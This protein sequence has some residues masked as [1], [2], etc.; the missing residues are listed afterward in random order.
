M[1]ATHGWCT[2]LTHVVPTGRYMFSLRSFCVFVGT[3]VVALALVALFVPAVRHAIDS[4]VTYYKVRFYEAYLYDDSDLEDDTSLREV[5]GVASMRDGETLHILIMGQSNAANEVESRIEDLEHVFVEYYGNIYRASDPMLGGTGNRGSVWTRFAVKAL[6]TKRWQNVVLSII[7][8]GGSALAYWMP[9]G[10]IHSRL[11]ARLE[12][13]QSL[14]F[15]P[16][17]VFW[18]HGETDALNDIPKLMYKNDF[19]D[20]VG[21]LR[22]FGIDNQVLVSQTT[23][24]RRMGSV[25]VRDALAEAADVTPQVILGPDT[26]AVG[27]DYRRDGCHFTDDGGDVVAGLWMDAVMEQEQAKLQREAEIKAAMEED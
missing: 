19:I 13:M 17:Y 12:A 8:Q 26:D 9:G 14:P 21:T 24:C 5:V 4:Y 3:I 1:R 15:R 16:D 2:C 20:L 18:F 11:L 10:P 6:A 27:F 25:G 23:L 7:A 22:K